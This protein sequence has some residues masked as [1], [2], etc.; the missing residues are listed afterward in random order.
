MFPRCLAWKRSDPDR[1]RRASTEKL[2]SSAALNFRSN[3]IRTGNTCKPVTQPLRPLNGTV[4]IIVKQ[5]AWRDRNLSG[6]CS[7]R[8][9][10]TILHL[11]TQASPTRQDSNEVLTRSA[12]ENDRRSRV[13]DVLRTFDK[14]KK[15]I[16]PSKIARYHPEYSGK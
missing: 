3:G 8:N 7:C 12:R 11:R 4:I 9:D 1:K 10:V 5:R 16:E 13:I 15:K 6:S 2:L 14:V